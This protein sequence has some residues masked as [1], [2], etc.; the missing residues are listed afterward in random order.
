MSYRKHP[1][2][3]PRWIYWVGVLVLIC[4]IVGLWLGR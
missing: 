3:T 1:P 2:E 4:F